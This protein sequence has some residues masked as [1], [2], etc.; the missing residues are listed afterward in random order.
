LFSAS[1]NY[2]SRP[3]STRVAFL[4]VFRYA[5][6]DSGAWAL[7]TPLVFLLAGR[8]SIRRTTF[9]WTVPL[10]IAASFA[11]ALLHLGIFIQML[12]WIGYNVGYAVMPAMLR[13][14]LHSNLLTCWVLFGLQHYRLR[15]RA[16][17]QLEARLV[18][19]QLEMLKMQLQP[20]FL[21]NT[22]HAISSLIHRDPENA[23]RMVA[24]LGDFLRLTLDSS[25][26]Q[27][28]TLKRELEYLDKYLEIE[29]VRFGSRLQV[30]RDIA[31]DTLDLLVPNLV[32]QP[33]AENAVR[34]GIAPRAEGG[35]IDVHARLD[36]HSL[37]IEVSDDGPGPST[38]M[39][40]GVGLA[41]TRARLEQL[42]GPGARLELGTRA[43]GGFVS[44]LT[45][46]CK[47]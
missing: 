39:Y 4:P 9:R 43:Q 37:E 22:L 40:E 21:F 7:L 25:G 36:G 15:Q 45:I 10:L 31:P 30:Y 2:L 26:V 18:Q 46:P 19:A 47:S 6:V 23:D 44:R 20:H 42:Y 16:A 12:P 35:R 1:Q 14:R 27:E 29:Q 17:A 11:F 13:A 41:N 32:L 3:Y 8:L 33:L 5:L 38:G 34:H 28:V 24:R